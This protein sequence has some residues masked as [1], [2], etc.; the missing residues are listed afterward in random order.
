MVAEPVTAGGRP[1]ALRAMRSEALTAQ[2]LPSAG[3]EALARSEALAPRGGAGRCGDPV[4]D[5]RRSGC[6]TE[7]AEAEDESRDGG[8]ATSAPTGRR[9]EDAQWSVLGHVG[10][11]RSGVSARTAY[12]GASTGTTCVV[13]AATAGTGTVSP[14]R[15]K[16]ASCRHAD[17]VDLQRTNRLDIRSGPRLRSR[18]VLDL[19]RGCRHAGEAS[20]VRSQKGHRDA[21]R[22]AK[23]ALALLRP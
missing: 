16:D 12:R 7:S 19:W 5:R 18:P 9:R 3:P 22:H 15:G 4:R 14:G 23:A 1:L 2:A 13:A 17:T 8:G 21:I 6:G 20:T 11:R 10:G